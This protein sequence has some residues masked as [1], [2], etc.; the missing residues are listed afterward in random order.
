MSEPQEIAGIIFKD[1]LQDRDNLKRIIHDRDI[2]RLKPMPYE[3]DDAA[4]EAAESAIQDGCLENEKL[5]AELEAV[6]RDRDMLQ[7]EQDFLAKRCELQNGVMFAASE[8]L[9]PGENCNLEIATAKAVERIAEL[10]GEVERRCLKCLGKIKKLEDEVERTRRERDE[11]RR[12]I[13]KLGTNDFDWDVLG[14]LDRLQTE[15]ERLTNG[16]TTC[17]RCHFAYQFNSRSFAK[18]DCPNCEIERLRDR[19]QTLLEA[20]E[21]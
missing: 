16:N 21:P 4:L 17:P 19:I 14:E 12:A 13:E 15:V 10:E 7:A 9:A 6:V 1:L 18:D 8:A 11:A 20:D 5:Q 3:I 2:G